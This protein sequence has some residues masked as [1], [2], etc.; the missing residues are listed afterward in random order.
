MRL[1][2]FPPAPSGMPAPATSPRRLVAGLQ[3]GIYNLAM[4]LLG[5][6]EDARDATQDILLRIV[7]HLGT[8]REPAALRGWAF[9]L[10]PGQ[11]EGKGGGN[12][13]RW[14]MQVAPERATVCPSLRETAA[15]P[16]A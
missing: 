11:A 16:G 5:H 4:R 15:G 13:R 8:P 12:Q 14:V 10:A 9:Q 2:A 6:R 3:P 7:T 1:L